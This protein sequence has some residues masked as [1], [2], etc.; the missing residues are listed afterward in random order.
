M[1]KSSIKKKYVTAIAITVFLMILI[2]SFIHN[3]RTPQF[4][5]LKGKAPFIYVEES[6]SRVKTHYVYSFEADCNDF[7]ALVIKELNHMDYKGLRSFSSDMAFSSW[8]DKH[9]YST[10]VELFKNYKLP[11]MSETYDNTILNPFF[12]KELCCDGW[13]SIQVTK[14][15]EQNHLIFEFKQLI[16]TLRGSH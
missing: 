3:E 13:V 8:N 16:Q 7:C 11:E 5:F 15:R 1:K 10:T 9:G 14:D 4:Q 6:G 12:H 2:F